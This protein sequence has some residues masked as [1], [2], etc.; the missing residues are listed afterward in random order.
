MIPE[1]PFEDVL[2]KAGI[3]LRGRNKEKEPEIINK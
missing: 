1:C 3:D 2:V